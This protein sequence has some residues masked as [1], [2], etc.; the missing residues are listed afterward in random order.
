MYIPDIFINISPCLAIPCSLRSREISSL[1]SE[2]YYKVVS[3]YLEFVYKGTCLIFFEEGTISSL[4]DPSSENC[5]PVL[6]LYNI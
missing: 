1:K 2:P 6:N 3:M 4:P 5:T